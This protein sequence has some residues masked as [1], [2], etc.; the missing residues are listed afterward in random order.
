MTM[1]RTPGVDQ[2]LTVI[3]RHQEEPGVSTGVPLGMAIEHLDSA[4]V[5]RDD[6]SW[7]PDLTR[8]RNL[9]RLPARIYATPQFGDG[10][11]PCFASMAKPS[12]NRGFRAPIK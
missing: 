8:K 5:A 7:V 9:Q 3:W 6:K 4:D 10:P 12:S 11:K 2:I 1:D